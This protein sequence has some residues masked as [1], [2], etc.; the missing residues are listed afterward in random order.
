MRLFKKRTPSKREISQDTVEI[1]ENI[2]KA[3]SKWHDDLPEEMKEVADRLAT[4]RSSHSV[5]L[6]VVCRPG[7]HF[8]PVSTEY[9]FHL[10][11]YHRFIVDIGKSEKL[12]EI[13]KAIWRRLLYQYAYDKRGQGEYAF[14]IHVYA[15]HPDFTHKH[16][17]MRDFRGADIR[18]SPFMVFYV[19][20]SREQP[21]LP[22]L[23]TM[24]PDLQTFMNDRLENLSLILQTAIDTPGLRRDWRGL[25]ILEHALFSYIS[26]ADD[27]SEMSSDYL[28]ADMPKAYGTEIYAS[29][30]LIR[31]DYYEWWN[32]SNFEY[33]INSEG[34]LVSKEEVQQRI[35]DSEKKLFKYYA[36][37]YSDDDLSLKVFSMDPISDFSRTINI[38]AEQG[39]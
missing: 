37:E 14:T 26:L 5:D 13:I 2:E 34:K 20:P 29:G 10:N 39:E 21:D 30:R 12:S 28:D 9:A 7:I 19:S 11:L 18:C 36:E 3:S 35:I 23:S 31:R 6:A 38:T 25:D 4:M 17:S 24:R 33:W 22:D 15:R 32:P 1:D 8:E 27:T 16:V